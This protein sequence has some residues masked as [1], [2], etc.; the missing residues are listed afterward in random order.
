MNDA[1]RFFYEHAGWG[2]SPGEETPEQGRER[3]AKAL[4]E[5]EAWAKR[6]GV[7]FRWDDDF[8]IDHV[9][10]FDCYDTEPETCEVCVAYIDGCVVAS[11]GCIDDADDNYRR[12]VMAELADEARYL[13]GVK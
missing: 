11:L 5:A 2:Y 9:A 1:E 10:E 13:E 4:A 7:E 12:V 6:E 8:G 3:G